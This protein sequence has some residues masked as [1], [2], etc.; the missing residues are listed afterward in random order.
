MAEDPPAAKTG[1]I[2]IKIPEEPNKCSAY[3]PSKYDQNAAYGLI[4]MI[5][6]FFPWRGRSWREWCWPVRR[7][8]GRESDSALEILRRRYASGEIT[9]EEFDRMKDDLE[10]DL[11]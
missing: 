3:I 8:A 10:D 5:F 4:V 7:I 11:S 9:K 1:V 2:E 6:V